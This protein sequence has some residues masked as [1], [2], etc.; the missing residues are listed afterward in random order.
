[1]VL[2]RNPDNFFAETEQAAFCRPTCRRASTSRETRCCR[3]GCSPTR[4]PSFAAGHGELPPDPD[5]RAKMSVP[6]L[7]ARRPHADAGAQGPRQLRAQQPGRGAART[8]GRANT[9]GPASAPRPADGRRE[10]ATSCA[11]APRRSPTITARRGCSSARRPRSSRRTSPRLRLRTVQGR[12]GAGAAADGRPIC[13]MSTRTWPSGSP[14]A[15]HRPAA[16]GQ[17]GARAD[18]HEAVPGALAS[19]KNMKQTLKGRAVGILVADGADGGDQDAGRA[20]KKAGRQG[21]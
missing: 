15:W 7:A 21:W 2:D 18:R 20:V 12:A 13:A 11:C 8:A 4:T 5:Q 10:R 19:G 9:R 1:M 16:K 6:E 17:G 3:A 14:P